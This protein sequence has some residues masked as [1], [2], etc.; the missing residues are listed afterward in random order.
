MI[1]LILAILIYSEIHMGPL[2]NL[3]QIYSLEFDA[4][5]GMLR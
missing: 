3:P 4:P 1:H 2:G 5:L